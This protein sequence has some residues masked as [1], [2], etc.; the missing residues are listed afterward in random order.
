[1]IFPSAVAVVHAGEMKNEAPS[2]LIEWPILPGESLSKL[3]RLIYPD[4]PR[5]QRHFIAATYRE[6]PEISFRKDAEQPF[7]QETVIRLPDLKHLS[8]FA[9]KPTNSRLARMQNPAEPGHNET[10]AAIADMADRNQ[11]LIRAQQALDARIEVLVVSIAEIGNAIAQNRNSKQDQVQS[12]SSNPSQ[13]TRT[14]Q[15]TAAGEQDFLLSA[16]SRYI[17]TGFAFL[18]TGIGA[19]WLRRRRNRNSDVVA[20]PVAA[21]NSL[22]PMVWE[23]HGQTGNSIDSSGRSK[24][25]ASDQR[26]GQDGWIS[27][28]EIESIVEEAKVFVA[29]GR[30]EHAIDVLEEYLAS[31]PRASAHPWLYL[32]EIYRSLQRRDD[33]E[34]T[35]KRFHQAMNVISPQWES[36]GQTMMVVPHSLEEFPHIMARLTQSWG[37]L[38]IHDFL[39]QLLQD[40]R[41][42]ERQGFSMEVLQEIL[43]LL[44]VLETRDHM[45]PL[46]SF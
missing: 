44:S 36:P 25:A 10:S 11:S 42:G 6:N 12:K 27:V 19:A 16:W 38:D 28:D 34:A 17:L 41:D 26:F 2:Q 22:N 18:L 32:M 14:V 40:N 23:K 9:T 35:S 8:R 24:A 13:P 31:H 39:N 43:L 33:F 7:T 46:R 15:A 3:A 30:S 20:V 4:D 21:E 1:M 29:L 5:M 45:P 37:T